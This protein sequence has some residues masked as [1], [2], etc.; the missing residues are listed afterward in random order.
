MVGSLTTTVQWLTDWETAAALPAA[1]GAAAPSAETLTLHHPDAHGVVLAGGKVAARCSVWTDGAI[2]FEGRPAGVIGHFAATT[3]AGPAAGKLLEAATERIRQAGLAA[4]IGPMDGNT[5]R[6]HRFLT[7][8]GD[9]PLFFLEADNSDEWPAWW[10]AAGFA[11]VANYYSAITPDLAWEDARVPLAAQRLP[12]AGV[13][14]RPLEPSRFEAELRAILALSVEAFAKNFLYTPIGPEEFIA[15]YRAMERRV[16][17]E[18]VQLAE[19]DGRLAGFCFAVPDLAQAARGEAVTNL[20]TKTLA[21][22]PGRRFAGLGAIL[23]A[24]VRTAARHAGFRHMI[25]AYMHADNSSLNLSAH[26]ATVFRRYTLLAHRT[27][28]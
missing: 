26:E 9:R 21:V 12:A 28:P 22:R 13:T 27:A 7:E 23:V 24:A 8:R 19:A 4:A 14:L 18:F 16:R 6:R 3:R 10:Q 5:W 15:Q 11:P 25:H 17:P 1:S 20:V 2:Q